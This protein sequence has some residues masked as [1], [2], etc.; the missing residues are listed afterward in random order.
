MSKYEEKR[1]WGFFK[2]FADNEK[3]TVKILHVDAGQILSKQYHKKRDELWIMLDDT[4]IAELDGKVLAL[5]KYG[6]VF[7]PKGSV[8]RLSSEKGGDVLEVSFG[9]F[10]ENDI[11]RV[12]DK[13]GRKS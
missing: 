13:Y 7:I 4:L 3:C 8:H 10:D 12:E 11:V 1:P 6:E 5:K 9:E 2:V